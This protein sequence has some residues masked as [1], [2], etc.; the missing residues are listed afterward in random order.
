MHRV[1]VG[2]FAVILALTT[3]LFADDWSKSFPLTGHPDLNVRTSDANVQV[4]P[5]D[6]SSV[7]V[8]IRTEHLKIGSG[9]LEIE[10]R[11]DGN[12][13][14][15]ETHEPHFSFSFFSLRQRIEVTIHMPPQA[16]IKITT[17]D[18]HIRVNGTQGT[19]DL[20]TGD[21]SQDVYSVAGSL[22]ATAGDGAIRVR[23]RFDQLDL[24]TGD[25]R[26]EATVLPGS[27]TV[28][29]WSLHSGDGRLTLELPQD[30]AATVDLHTSDGHLD[31]DLPLAVTG[32][33]DKNSVRGV[34]NG[35]GG[36]VSVRTGDGSILLR[37]TTA[38]I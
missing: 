12:H 29:D 11:Q 28:S 9:G 37:K 23:G 13:I 38:S 25:G 20:R 34:L 16:N 30:F 7:D 17:G 18:G 33:L 35:G 31:L 24:H 4:E 15:L 19:L 22:R 1:I 36:T 10:A 21:G 8:H 3:R 5:W 27:K 14:T 26:I 6:K 2:S 32:R